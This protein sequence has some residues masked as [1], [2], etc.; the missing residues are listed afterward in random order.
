MGTAGSFTPEKLVMCILSSRRGGE[1]ELL[2]PLVELW[3]G[4]DFHCVPFPFTF[5]HYYDAEM[6]GPIQR[7]FVSFS[8]LVDPSSL[9]LIKQQT[10]ALEDRFRVDGL[11][12]VNLDPG[13]MAL[14][15]FTLAT[16][17]ESAH[18]IPL[19]GGI[20]AEITLLYARGSFRSLEWTYPDYRSER[21]ISL[22][23]EIRALYK[24]QLAS[25]ARE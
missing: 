23:N 8:R 13:L 11:R 24:T 17:K 20:Y 18:R 5:T 15:R 19:E 16:T 4:V 12:T 14:S 22:L 3:G 9:A 7:S 2:P 10:N 6:G 21:Y 25:P 1:E